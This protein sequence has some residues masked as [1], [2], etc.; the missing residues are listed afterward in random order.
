MILDQLFSIKLI[1]INKMEPGTFIMVH[2]LD[3]H[4]DFHSP[5]DK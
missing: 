4:I 1:Y 5:L 2:Y 3:R